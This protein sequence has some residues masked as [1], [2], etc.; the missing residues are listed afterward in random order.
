MV[1]FMKSFDANSR[2]IK[3]IQRNKPK[4]FTAKSSLQMG[5]Q[6][7][8]ALHKIRQLEDSSR[9]YREE[10][11]EI[12]ITQA[13]VF[14]TQL[15]GP[16]KLI[17]GQSAHY[18]CRIEPFP[19]PDLK[20]EWFFNGNSLQIGHRFRTAY[21]F[22]FATLDIL[23][24]YGEDSGEYTCRVTNNFGSVQSSIELYVQSN[25]FW[26]IFQ[27]GAYFRVRI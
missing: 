15:N 6:H 16:T 11:E 23:T 3:D 2:L 13:P 26:S 14:T 9:Y 10:D 18:E 5:T 4:Y 7:V 19:D 27:A 25:F 24:V 8:E 17:E 22:G 21:D 12:E 20:V 1:S